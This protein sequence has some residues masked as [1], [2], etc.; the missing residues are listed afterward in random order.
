[1]Q[2][3]RCSHSLLA[4]IQELHSCITGSSCWT[5]TDEKILW[6]VWRQVEWLE[7]KEQTHHFDTQVKHLLDA[8][9]G[10]LDTYLPNYSKVE[11]YKEL[12]NKIAQIKES[13]SK[14]SIYNNDELPD[15]MKRLPD[16]MFG[17]GHG[18]IYKLGESWCADYKLNN[19][20]EVNVME[21]QTEINPP[22]FDVNSYSIDLRGGV[23]GAPGLFVKQFLV[24]ALPCFSGNDYQKV[25]EQD[26]LKEVAFMN[27]IVANFPTFKK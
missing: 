23:Y 22:R 27:Y 14:A 9:L 3:D 18:K 17:A 24:Q 7:G 2:E 4:T 10:E 26:I 5:I 15:S 25:I 11:K 6:L 8:V 16:Q 21:P 19:Y 20:W 12:I 13:N 1:M